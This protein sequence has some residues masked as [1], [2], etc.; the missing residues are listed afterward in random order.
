[1]HK[2]KKNILSRHAK[3]GRYLDLHISAKQ[4]VKSVY[5]TENDTLHPSGTFYLTK[6]C[7]C[8][9]LNRIS[10]KCFLPSTAASDQ[11]LN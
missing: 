8:N 3:P 2:C 1:M 5:R 7:I 6:N 4:I 9:G 11:R 10:A